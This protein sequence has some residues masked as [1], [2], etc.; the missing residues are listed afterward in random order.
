MSRLLMQRRPW[1]IDNDESSSDESDS[2]DDDN[3]RGLR[4]L[5]MRR[6]RSTPDEFEGR[7]GQEVMKAVYSVEPLL[8]E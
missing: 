8:P 6:L 2:G 5:D 3:P 7:I 4:R 1:K